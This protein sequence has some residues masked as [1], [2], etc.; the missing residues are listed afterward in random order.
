M[1]RMVPITVRTP[2]LYSPTGFRS[3][4]FSFSHVCRLLSLSRLQCLVSGPLSYWLHYHLWSWWVMLLDC[5]IFNPRSGYIRSF[6]WMSIVQASEM[7][8][9][10]YRKESHQTPTSKNRCH[11]PLSCRYIQGTNLH[12]SF[13]PSDSFPHS[14]SQLPLYLINRYHP[15]SRHYVRR[16][17]WTCNRARYFASSHID[18]SKCQTWLRIGKHYNIDNAFGITP[19]GA[20]IMKITFS[21]CWREHTKIQYW[22]YGWNYT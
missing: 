13:P 12:L 10:C 4:A 16:I 5:N 15:Q 19:N 18:V 21:N 11:L 2:Y 8:I 20:L 1:R 14:L 7:L 6:R 9:F 17:R 3:S 22:L